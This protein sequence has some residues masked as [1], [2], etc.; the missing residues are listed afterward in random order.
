LAPRQKSE[1]ELQHDSRVKQAAIWAKVISDIATGLIK[2]GSIA[3]VAWCVSQAVIPFA[4]KISIA[5]LGFRGELNVPAIDE[6]VELLKS[7][8]TVGVLGLVVG[9]GGILFGRRERRLRQNVIADLSPYQQKLE[10]MLDPQRSSSR[11]TPRG[12]TNP[13]DE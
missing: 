4:G 1:R 11:L 8:V 5:D 6:L 3:F 7:C 9:V 2:W 12:E 10:S 13:G